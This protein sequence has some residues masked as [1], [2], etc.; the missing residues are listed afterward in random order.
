M[1]DTLPIH[2][3]KAKAYNQ[4]VFEGWEALLDK[5]ENDNLIQQDDCESS[6]SENIELPKVNDPNYSLKLE[7]RLTQMNA[8]DQLE[9]DDLDALVDVGITHSD[10][11]LSAFRKGILGTNKMLPPLETIS[12]T[13]ND[14][15]YSLNTTYWFLE[16]EREYFN[17]EGQEFSLTLPSGRIADIVNLNGAMTLFALEQATSSALRNETW[18]TSNL[19]LIAAEVLSRTER[20][21]SNEYDYVS[22]S[23]LAKKRAQARHKKTYAIQNYAIEQANI[24]LKDHPTYNTSQIFKIIFPSVQKFAKD[25]GQPFLER[26]QKT[27]YEW[28]LENKNT[29]STMQT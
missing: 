15:K 3:F 24:I 11:Q 4:F 8:K 21:L 29:P 22:A 12:H 27:V 14:A 1:S 28:L 17:S 23:R 25:I 13:Y 16:W 20:L 2:E 7:Q 19:L 9:I 10:L 18:A 6:N 26:G 5:V